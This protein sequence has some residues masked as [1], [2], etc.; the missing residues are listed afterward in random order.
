MGSYDGGREDWVSRVR[1]S[2]LD[3]ESGQG[4][5]EWAAVAGEVIQKQILKESKVQDT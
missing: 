1:S 4:L 2:W 5:R 3:R